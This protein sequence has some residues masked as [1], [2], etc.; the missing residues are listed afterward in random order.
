MKEHSELSR[1]NHWLTYL[2]HVSG[3]KNTYRMPPTLSTA[4]CVHNA[5]TATV[6]M[7]VVC[8][9]YDRRYG[10]LNGEK[11]KKANVAVTTQS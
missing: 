8:A 7:S 11:P 2:P 6:F 3:L 10:G 9:L 1:K 4:V 5:T